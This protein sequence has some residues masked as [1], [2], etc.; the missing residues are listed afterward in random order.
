MPSWQLASVISAS[1]IYVGRSMLF[2]KSSFLFPLCDRVE[3]K[4]I[5]YVLELSKN[6]LPFYGYILVKI[7]GCGCFSFKQR[8]SHLFTDLIF[9]TVYFRADIMQIYVFS[10]QLWGNGDRPQIFQCQKVWF[11]A[12]CFLFPH[13]KSVDDFDFLGLNY[14]LPYLCIR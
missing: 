12:L 8:N 14:C 9:R 4:L 7:R 3:N 2:L 6:S 1:L 13:L 5:M 11:S 10:V